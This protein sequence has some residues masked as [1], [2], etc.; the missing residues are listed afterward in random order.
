MD[1]RTLDPEEEGRR[2]LGS[3]YGNTPQARSHG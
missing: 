1:G 2:R 3:V